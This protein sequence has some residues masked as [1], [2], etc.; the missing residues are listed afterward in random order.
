MYNTRDYVLVKNISML[1][2]RVTSHADKCIHNYQTNVGSDDR[3]IAWGALLPRAIHRESTSTARNG[4]VC[5]RVDATDEWTE[6]EIE[7][8]VCMCM[9]MCAMRRVVRH[10]S[11]RDRYRVHTSVS[12]H[13]FT[14]GEGLLDSRT[15]FIPRH[16]MASSCLPR[17]L[18]SG[19]PVPSPSFP[20]CNSARKTRG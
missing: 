5:M 2:Y 6:I 14:Y 11:S 17:R 1:T 18:Q 16:Q 9:C 7:A 13:G 20:L 3:R 8:A 19:Q 10:E 12:W 4:S 15:F